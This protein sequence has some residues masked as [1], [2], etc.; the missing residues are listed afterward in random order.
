MPYI[1]EENK[2]ELPGSEHL[3]TNEAGSAGPNGYRIQGSYEPEDV[4]AI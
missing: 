4:E 2:C 1:K 3:Y